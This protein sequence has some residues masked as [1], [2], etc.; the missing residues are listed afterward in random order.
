VLVF[1]RPGGFVMTIGYGVRSDWVRNLLA[2]GGG[3]LVHRRRHYVLTHPR[4]L[5]GTD[6]LEVLPVG[7]RAFARVVRVEGVLVVDAEVA[8]AAA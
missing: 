3:G 2:A 7:Y 6:A 5:T 4:V 8:T 1:G